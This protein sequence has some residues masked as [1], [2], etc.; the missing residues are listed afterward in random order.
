MYYL[1]TQIKIKFSELIMKILCNDLDP[2][3]ID[4]RHQNAGQN[5]NIGQKTGNIS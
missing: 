1:Y 5:H 4:S 2:C 3:M